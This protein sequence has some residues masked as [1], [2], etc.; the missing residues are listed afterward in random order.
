MRMPPLSEAA[1]KLLPSFSLNALEPLFILSNS[2]T[3]FLSKCVSESL[4]RCRNYI[5]YCYSSYFQNKKE[6]SNNN[7]ELYETKTMGQSQW[8]SG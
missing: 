5:V 4:L 8:P 2:V 6:L 1:T 3:P 7:K